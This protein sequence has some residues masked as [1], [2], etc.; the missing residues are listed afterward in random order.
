MSY[1]IAYTVTRVL[2]YGP[3]KTNGLFGQNSAH[4]DV[5]QIDGPK[6]REQTFRIHANKVSDDGSSHSEDD[7][8]NAK[9]GHYCILPSS[10]SISRHGY[11]CFSCSG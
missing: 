9:V 2:D 1:F 3:S 5:E 6:A 8:R 4:A 11:G 7:T 10:V